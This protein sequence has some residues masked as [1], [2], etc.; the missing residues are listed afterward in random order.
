MTRTSRPMR[1]PKIVCRDNVR[2]VYFVAQCYTRVESS[3]FRYPNHFLFEMDFAVSKNYFRF[4]RNYRYI[5]AYLQYIHDV[6][7]YSSSA[8]N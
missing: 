1:W 3:D 5:P 7:H 4:R 8:L 6:E 2:V